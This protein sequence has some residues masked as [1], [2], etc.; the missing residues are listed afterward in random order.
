MKKN[1]IILIL[2]LL[3]LVSI[4]TFREINREMAK[5]EGF[6]KAPELTGISGYF[7]TDEIKISDLKGKV[8]L[9][10]FWTYSCINCIRTLP[11][12]VEW[13]KKYRDM[14]L[15][16]IG[17]HTPE[18]DFE[19][20]P[21]NVQDAIEKFGIEY[22]VVQDNDYGTWNA[23]SNRFWPH[24][25][26]IDSKGNIR[27]DHVG[28]GGYEE[29]EKKIQELLMEIDK[30][31]ANVNVSKLEDKT[32]KVKTTSEL[33]AGFGFALPRGQNIGNKEGLQPGKV[34]SYRVEGDIKKD[35]IYLEGMWRNNE[36][37][38]RAQDNR[39]ASVILGFTANSVN[40]VAD[41]LNDKPLKVEVFI[42]GEY[43]DELNAGSDV[44][45][46]GKRAYIVI[47]KP[48]LYNLFNG[49]YGTYLLKL[50]T[51]SKDFAFNA[52]TFG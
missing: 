8:V 36:D 25:Y 44:E 51:D 43:I 17:V 6:Q 11:H 46:D 50:R 20:K 41:S 27:Y 14:G 39:S 5:K 12:L 35:V 26:L 9:V 1:N 37:N 45:F 40:I 38:L 16:I 47:D 29:T 24:K 48:R 32:P 23:Y 31:A 22:V 42:N 28:E 18:F 15:V 2:V 4:I 3:L 33:Y 10:D 49:H 7:N 13:D 34:I 30:K 21:E 19:K 52:F